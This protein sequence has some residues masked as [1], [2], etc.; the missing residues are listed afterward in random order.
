MAPY[1]EEVD[2]F[3]APHSRMK[4]LVDVYL[5]KIAQYKNHKNLANLCYHKE[6]FDGNETEWHFYATACGKGVCDGVGGTVKILSAKA[7]LQSQIGNQ[8]LTPF[9][10]FQWG[11]KNLLSITFFYVNNEE[12]VVEEKSLK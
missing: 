11:V 9:Q 4:S 2:V 5:E 7:S 12:Y 6:D 1:P 3:S 8:I 10:L